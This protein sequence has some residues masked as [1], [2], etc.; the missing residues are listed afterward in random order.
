MPYLTPSTEA[1]ASSPSCRT[2]TVGGELW[3]L[4]TGALDELSKAYR[5][6]QHGTATPEQMAAYFMDV[7]D[8]YNG[9]SCGG[10]GMEFID[11][12]SVTLFS[13]TISYTGGQAK[14]VLVTDL[15][16]EAQEAS[17][18]YLQIDV[19]A[20][21]SP[22][23]DLI[24][25][26]NFA[27]ARQNVRMVSGVVTAQLLCPLFTGGIRF[28]MNAPPPFTLTWSAKLVGWM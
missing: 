3:Y 19:T 8:S 17:A 10:A 1:L 5:W 18:V 9:S 7:L 20:S 13:E 27:F 25:A 11:T 26:G 16:T 12:A 4:V 15:P 23:G 22:A 24:V 28:S 2:I 14:V 6:E 21:G